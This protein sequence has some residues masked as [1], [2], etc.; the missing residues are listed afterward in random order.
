VKGKFFFFKKKQ[1]FKCYNA[2]GMG[3]IRK[4]IGP[5]LGPGTMISCGIY[6]QNL[7]AVYP[8]ICPASAALKLSFRR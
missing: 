5:V 3:M 7:P 1:M 8:I 2:L 6:F 4:T